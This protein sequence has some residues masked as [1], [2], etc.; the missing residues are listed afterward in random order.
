MMIEIGVDICIHSVGICE[1]KR[2]AHSVSS[3]LLEFN[4]NPNS[5]NTNRNVI[6]YYLSGFIE[7]L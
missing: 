7:N 4:F 2:T 1:A 3:Q 6:V 5:Q